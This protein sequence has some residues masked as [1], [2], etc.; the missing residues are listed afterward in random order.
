MRKAIGNL[1][2]AVTAAPIENGCRTITL[3]MIQQVAT[4]TAMR[5]DKLGDDHYD[6]VSAY[7]NPCAALTRTLHCTIWAACLRQ[8]ICPAP[9]AA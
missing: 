8:G 5:Y 3:D 7:R 2:F 9:A 4:R 1:E 6:I